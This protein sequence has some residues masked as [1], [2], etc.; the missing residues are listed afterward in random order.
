MEYIYDAPINSSTTSID[1][2]SLEDIVMSG[3]IDNASL[4]NWADK[5][6]YNRLQDILLPR[7]VLF[8]LLI[9]SYNNLPSLVTLLSLLVSYANIVSILGFSFSVRQP[10]HPSMYQ[11]VHSPLFTVLTFAGFFVYLNNLPIMLAQSSYF[12]YQS[13]FPVSSP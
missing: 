11:S 10:Q 8:G 13:I 4:P 12:V 9:R 1:N 3:I 5:W 6:K 7:R 2:V